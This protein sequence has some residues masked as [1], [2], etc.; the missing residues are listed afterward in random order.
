M[1]EEEIKNYFDSSEANINAL[2]DKIDSLESAKKELSTIISED[3]CFFSASWTGQFTNLEDTREFKGSNE[4]EYY[5]TMYDPI[6]SC[7]DLHEN[8][9][10]DLIDKIESEI[11]SI[12]K[13][14]EEIESERQKVFHDLFFE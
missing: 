4:L 13:K 8:S 12:K 11:E 5:E 14:I 10:Y 6:F 7:I 9:L 2:N 1:N 3:L